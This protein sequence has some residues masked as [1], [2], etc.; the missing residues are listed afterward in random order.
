MMTALNKAVKK[1]PSWMQWTSVRLILYVNHKTFCSFFS[2]LRHSAMWYNKS[3]MLLPKS[4]TLH[5][6][7]FL[8]SGLLDKMCEDLT[9]DRAVQ[10]VRDNWQIKDW[11][12]GRSSHL[13]NLAPNFASILASLTCPVL[14][15]LF[16]LGS[17]SLLLWQHCHK[18]CVVVFSESKSSFNEIIWGCP[19]AAFEVG[20]E[21]NPFITQFG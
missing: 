15:S 1:R 5:T 2:V 20:F 12:C 16:Q 3:C 19:P 9:D 10:R 18:I 11:L 8:N 17:H 6:V 7:R 4:I 13:A 14:S 21:L